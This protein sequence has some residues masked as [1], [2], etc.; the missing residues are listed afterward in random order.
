MAHFGLGGGGGGGGGGGA[1]PTVCRWILSYYH[2]NQ[3]AQLNPCVQDG[4]LTMWCCKTNAYYTNIAIGDVMIVFAAKT[5][6][7]DF[8]LVMFV[9]VW[10][11]DMTVMDY[12]NG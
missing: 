10:T 7:A 1:H 11:G 2:E 8:G 12:L 6:A 4:L 5:Y 3:P 9:C